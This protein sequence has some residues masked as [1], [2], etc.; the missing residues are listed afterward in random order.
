MFVLIAFLYVSVP[1]NPVHGW[2][3]LPQALFFLCFQTTRLFPNMSVIGRNMN[4]FCTSCV[5]TY[6]WKHQIDAERKTFLEMVDVCPELSSRSD[7]WPNWCP[8]VLKS[9]S[10]CALDDPSTPLPAGICRGGHGGHQIRHVHH[11]FG[12]G[13]GSAAFCSA[14]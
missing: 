11:H 1:P 6:C 14:N 13:M 5:L 9:G 8:K 7:R 3:G 10:D 4:F 2:T 12:S